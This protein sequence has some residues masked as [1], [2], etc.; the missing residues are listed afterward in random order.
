MKRYGYKFEKMDGSF[1]SAIDARAFSLFFAI[2]FFIFFGIIF[3]YRAGYFGVGILYFIVGFISEYFPKISLT[4][5]LVI[6]VLVMSFFL[7]SEYLLIDQCYE[8]CT[9]WS[10]RNGKE[11][12]ISTIWQS[13]LLGTFFLTY[14]IVVVW[15]LYLPIKSKKLTRRCT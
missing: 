11:E 2:A 8:N 13:L 10:K 15:L 6:L 7:R 9:P 4:I 12:R 1:T 3:G 14:N 5:A